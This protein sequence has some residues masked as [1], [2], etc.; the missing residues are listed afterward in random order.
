MLK[1]NSALSMNSRKLQ[2]NTLELICNLWKQ[3]PLFSI[4]IHLV[5]VLFCNLIESFVFVPLHTHNLG[6]NQHDHIGNTP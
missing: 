2:N 6:S 3:I 1:L 4:N 5:H